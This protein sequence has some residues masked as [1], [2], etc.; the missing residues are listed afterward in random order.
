MSETEDRLRQ[1]LKRVTVDLGQ[2]R[3]RLREMEER[4][5]E[6]VAIVAMACRF[7]GGVTSPEELWELV[8]SGRDAIGGF[9][10]N[11]GWDLERLYH[12]DP[13]HPGT[14]Y[15]REGGFLHD[16]DLFDAALFGISPREALAMDPQQRVLLEVSWE[17]LERAGIAPASLKV[18]PTGV[19]VGA[20]VPGFGTPHIDHGSEGYL[21]TGNALSV[22]SGRVSYTLGLEGPALTVD[23]AC[24][25]S[26]VALHLACH[27]L[28]QGE[29]TLA[30]AGGVTVMA[31]P[32]MFTEFS[33]Q[34]ALSPD[35]RC[36][37]FAMAADGTGFSEGVGLVLLERLSDARRNG[38]R[39][40]AVVR[41]SAVNQDGTSN[42]L[43]A[44]NGPS[45]Q[46]VI[47]RALA[48]AGLSAAEVDVV[49][50]HG[51]GTRL[52]DPLEAQALL[53]TYGQ[54][55]PAERP[56]LL[57]SVKSNIGHTQGAAGV[58]GV[59]KMVMAMRHGALPASL[60][61][62]R[63]TEHVD[64]SS[65]A[66]SPVTEAVEWARADHPR[67]AGV[68]A[69]GMSGT[70]AHLILEE[71]PEPAVRTG[72][73][74]PLAERPGSFI[75]PWVVSARSEVALRAQAA[76]LVE[77]VTGGHEWSPADVGWSLST[78]RSVFEH[79]AVILG[80]DRDELVAGMTALARGEAH[81][82]LVTDVADGAA[83]GPVLVFPGQGGQWAGMGAELLESSP[84][85]AARIAE[86]ERALSPY[87]D[88]SLTEVLRD[89]AGAGLDRVDVVQPALWAVMVAL[90][91]L[92]AHHGVRPAAVVGHSQ[93][94]IAAACV[95]GA[96]SL[97]EGA[98]IVAVR[99]KALRRLS[100]H[101]TMASLGVGAEDAARLLDQAKD[102]TVAAVNGPSSTVISGFPDQV[103]AVVAAA[104]EQGLR[105]R[106]IDVDYASHGPQVDQITDELT[107][108]LAGIQPTPST[109]AFYSTVTGTRT[110][111]TTLD[112]DYWITNLR[113]PV[114][115]A[116][117]VEA[118]LDD[119]YRTFI[120][121][122]PHP[123]LTV[124]LQECLERA[125]IDGV[126][127]PTLRRDH[128]DA[129]QLMR[130]TAQAFAAGVEVDRSTWFPASAECGIVD[131]PTYAFQRERFWLAGGTDGMDATGLGLTPAGHPLLGAAVEL[132]DGDGYVL[133]GRLSRQSVAWLTDHELLGTVLLPGAL[134]VEWALRAADGVGCAGV[135]ELTLQAPLLLPETGALRI[136]VTVGAVGDGGRREVRVHSRPDDD[137]EAEWACHA[138]GTLT[139]EPVPE[140]EPLGGAWPPAGAEPADI[141][142]FYQRVAALGYT[143]GPAFRGLRAA[144]RHG[145]DLLAEVVLPEAAG[146][147]DGFGIHP[148]LLDAALHPV[149]LT[150]MLDDGAAWVP[151][152]WEGVSLHAVGA[153]T[154]RVR[155]SPL[156][157]ELDQ[158]FRLLVTDPAGDPV[159]SVDAVRMR[160]ADPDLRNAAARR[161][162]GL[163]ALDWIP[164]PGALAPSASAGADCAIIASGPTAPADGASEAVCHPTLQALAA[165]VDAGSA[166][167]RL[168]LAEVPVPGGTDPAGAGLAVARETLRLAQDWLAE[169]GLG[170]GHF[171]VVTRD[172]VTAT[173]D[174]RVCDPPAAA[175]WGLVRSAQSE[176]PDRFIL[177][178][179]DADTDVTRLIGAAS[180]AVKAGESQVAI[181]EGRLLVPRLRRAAA[182]DDGDRSLDPDG[183]VLITGGTG[184]LG[185]LV[186]EHLVR[187]GETGRLLLLSRRG[188]DAPGAQDLADRLA[189]LG[190]EVRIAAVDV[191]DAEALADT[192]RRIDPAHPLTG[193]IH[194]AGVLDDAMVTAQTPESLAR[195]WATKATAAA[196]L[197]RATADV[198]LAMFVLFSSAAAVMGSPGQSNYAAANAFCDALAAHRRERGLAGLSVAWG[199]W[200]D[201][202]GMTG[203]LSESGLVAR[204]SRAGIT[205]MPAGQ[206]LALLDAARRSGTGFLV[207]AGMDVRRLADGPVPVVLRGLVAP[208]RRRAAADG[209]GP[210]LAGRLAALEADRRSEA[211]LDVVREQ[212]AVVLGH[213]SAGDV[214]VEASF[215]NLGF[216][217]LTAVELRNRLATVTGLR[218]PATLAFDHPTPRTLAEHLCAR[219]TGEGVAPV[220]R[221]TSVA[222][223][224]EPIAIV[225]MACRYPGGVGSPE[226]LWDLVTSGRDA[227]GSFPEDR[228][229]N[230]E[231]LFAPGPDRPGTSHTRQ[232]GFLYDAGEFDA[233]F[234]G[235]S[236]REALASD[237]QQRLL[238]ETAW[239]ALERAGID[240]ASLKG[241]STG[242]YAGAM[243][244][245]Y[246]DGL[247]GAD[248]AMEGYEWLTG[249]GS[250][251]SGRT[252]FTFGFEGPAVTVDTACSSSLVA[253][254]L[255]CNAL[256][257]GEC[258]LALAGGVT[259]MATPSPFVGFSRQR[260]LAPD[261]RCKSFAASAD[262]TAISEGA[263]LVLLERLSDARRNGRRVLGVVRGS[264]VNQDGASNGLT[265]PNGPSQE[266]VI[267]A[268]LASA[269]L[270]P[271]DVDVVE[272]HGTG[273]TLG[274]PIEANALLAAYGR[275]RDR[276]LLVG[277][278]KSNIGH[279]QAAAGVAGVIK[280][281]LAMRRGVVPASLH[282]DEPSPHVDW[283]SGAVELVTEA[284]EWPGTGRPR[285]AGVSSFG[286]SG[287]NA[288]V[289]LEEAPE[290]VEQPEPAPMAGVL[291]WVIS[292]RG[293][294]ALRGQAAALAARIGD[295]PQADPAD[296]AWSLVTTRSTFDDRAVIVGDDRD[297]L[298]SGL[299]ALATGRPHP[300]L[301]EPA[302]RVT[303]KTV[304]LFS[305]QG[306]Q[307]VGMG[308]GLYGRFAV[309]ADAFDEVCGRLDPVLGCS[310][311]DVVF[312]GRGGVL[313][314]TTCAQ[315]GLFAVQVGLARLLGSFG[316]VPDVVIGH[317]IGEVAA[318]Y[319]AGVFD[320]GDACRLVGARAVLMGGLPVGGG[321]VAVEA[322]EEEV[323]ADVAALG[324]RVSVAA[325]NGPVATVVSGPVEL[326]ARVGAVW[327]G[328]GRKTK[329]LSVSHGFHSALM[330]PMLGE[331]GAAI[332]GVVF[333]VPVV[334]LVSNVSGLR[335]GEEVASPG[336][337]VRQVRE[338]VRFGPAVG[339]VAGEAGV[340]VELGPDPV[341][342]TAAQQ[343]LDHLADSDPEPAGDRPGPFLLS[344]L[345]RKQPEV[346]GL[347]HA[348]ARLHAA[349][350]SV[351][352]STWF[353][354]EPAR[355][356]V[357][358]PTY[359]FQRERYWLRGDRT[360]AEV[361]TA[362][363]RRLEH[364]LLRAATPLADGGLLLT[365]RLSATGDTDWLADHQVLGTVLVPGAVLAEW[366]L[367]AA[368]ESGCAGVEELVLQTPLVLPPSGDVA[369]Q[370]V[371]GSP[372]ADARRE[373]RVYSR[374]GDS[375]A[376]ADAPWTCHAT[377]LLTAEM[378]APPEPLD[379][380]WP[381]A[382]AE[383]LSTD[384]FYREVAAAGYEYGAA[385]QGVRAVWRNGA[386]LFATVELPDSVH[387][388][389]R[390]GIHPVLLDATLHAGLLDERL[391]EGEV[392]LPFLWNGVRL[393]AEKATCVR[394]R[395]TLPDTEKG[396]DGVRVT[397]ADTTGAP[398]L[399][400]GSLVTRPVPAGRPAFPGGNRTDGLFAVDWA[401]LPATSTE[402][403][404]DD[405]AVLG[406]DEP[407]LDGIGR[408]PGRPDQ[409]APAEAGPRAHYQDLEALTA[410]VR[411]GA[412]IAPIILTFVRPTGAG[413]ADGLAAS[414][415]AL[416]LLQ[417]WLAEPALAGAR[418]V[419]VT[420]GA[421]MTDAADAGPD[422]ASAAVW[423]LTRTAQAE[424]PG[425]FLLVDM[426]EGASGTGLAEAA[427]RAVR[428][429]ESEVAI[430]SDQV[431]V[432]RLVPADRRRDLVVP[433]GVRAWRLAVAEPGT[434]DNLVPVPCPEVLEPPVA[435]QVRVDVR[436]AGIN[437][438]DVLVGL[439]MVPGHTEVGGEGAGVVTAVGPG[440]MDL[441]VGDRVMGLF[442]GAFG[443]VT[444]ADARM[445]GP[446]PAG[447]GWREAAAAPVAFLT[448]WYGLVELAGLRPGESVLIH[449]A[450]GGVGM[451]A[452]QI[453]RHLGAE[454]YTTAS[455]GKHPVLEE[456]GVDAAHRASSR[457]LGFEAA[458]RE[459]TGGRG[460]DVVLNSLAGEFTDASLR[461]LAPGGRF[462][463]M[464]KTDIRESAE[465]TAEHPDVRYEVFDL[466]GDAGP[467]LIRRMLATLATLFDAGTLRPAPVRAWPLMRAR[468]ALRYLGQA[469]HV[470]KLVL[471]VPASLDPDGTVLITGGTGTLGGLVA[472]RFV[473]T[474]GVKRLVLV[475]RRGL[476]APGAHDLVTR[477]TELGGDVRVVAA[478]VGD[479]AAVADLIKGIDPRHPLT[480]VVH[481]AGVVADAVVTSQSR[482]HLARVWSAKAAAAHHLH[483]A[484]ADLEPALFVTFSST[485][486][487]LGSP[488]Q[489]NYAAAN[490]FCDA[491]A[492]HHQVTG[493][494]GLSI[495]W[496]LW[497]ETSGM[498]AGLSAA[499]L[500]RMARAGVGALTTD[501]ALSLL[502][503]ADRY[504]DPHLLAVNLDLRALTAQ[505]A[506]TLPPA[507]RA[508]AGGEGRIRPTAVAADPRSGDRPTR[509]AGLSETEQQ[510][511]LLDLVRSHVAAV[512]GHS[513]PESV[514]ADASFK[515]LGFDSLTAVELR[516]RLSSATGL[517]LPPALIFDYPQARVLADHLRRRMR[518]EDDAT[519]G[520]T[521]VEPVLGE[522]ARL[523]STLQDLVL[524]DGDSTAVTAR[525]ESLVAKWKA[526]LTPSNGGSAAERLEVA[527]TDQVLDFIDNELGLS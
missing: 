390:F 215:R 290:P 426:D 9:P 466:V 360:A 512:L 516:N 45:Q 491:L 492:A 70:N 109:V 348:L 336:Y 499:D 452:V 255:A 495:G 80:E 133:T 233:G 30:L 49:E 207:A 28:R 391:E 114:R 281:V 299:D 433:D 478:D 34:R 65:G 206:G 73:A 97:E 84:V 62:D 238:L 119:G 515:D 377:G 451:A 245:D 350:R 144:W 92:W 136:Q 198:P 186:A 275:G 344:A 159:L 502:D 185:G 193:V 367:R 68:S 110:D 261:G 172:A 122:G 176:N 55:R 135:D 154:V 329:V 231:T 123:L 363:S 455:P 191:T 125:G 143:Y 276:A 480:G 421:V 393:W 271:G 151:F 260:G 197:H 196:N 474:R 111:T 288:H 141:G 52:G 148:V 396:R 524:N 78:A 440:V 140:A 250:V 319:V 23:T 469:R 56:L 419:L 446:V 83:V 306:S 460:V 236:P 20:G 511:V 161:T 361:D 121:V 171:V 434:V 98:R 15:V 409:V 268:A 163:F 289:I 3:Q 60:H 235:I 88:W 10:T 48:A 243:Y 307:R 264:A 253:M 450:T 183:T 113:R 380:R 437:F 82:G 76:T 518:P 244:H 177:L 449:T 384:D 24:S 4:H 310:L 493:R 473:R 180:E 213:G 16:A 430:R 418:L 108:D 425:R 362:V 79:R 216:D 463:E 219:L 326:V 304:F 36:K 287:T 210:A 376:S 427:A 399:S 58:A 354:D 150:G 494:P 249:S 414:E 282:V 192:I 222:R 398:V 356:R 417:G 371:V 75:V 454:V 69:F 246:A 59:I 218:L 165:A 521:D 41:G 505:P 315:A 314:H 184:T 200:A 456:M 208:G 332:E 33:R 461:L 335:A 39:V 158:G 162:R 37:P 57:G 174:D 352:W 522:L 366:A 405:W 295:D 291:P 86:C 93:G 328:R 160:P 157:K 95:A 324:G 445:V 118:L 438:R 101:G 457:D 333:R 164:L 104:Q 294:E 173:S 464:G 300:G 477:L 382:G 263:G 508:L 134:L 403:E 90:A 402:T 358:L 527:S 227:I 35:G 228:G 2:T 22:L 239:E 25:S 389:E 303:G 149:F 202:S 220:T 26:L 132:A 436:A 248:A 520:V 479:P 107:A 286:A 194:A 509:L 340:F 489:A 416:E 370:V 66:V 13:D 156:G 17:L 487:A 77:W 305:G 345:S 519:P 31:T 201:A 523:E 167:P 297:R 378:S 442:A 47:R 256:R 386:D 19:Y 212:V 293:P 321:M 323:A 374:P 351:D 394:V 120:E 67:R 468:Q 284:V 375:G 14:S 241:S 262:G 42:G 353:S 526:T 301:V 428:A 74:G 40:L 170:D 265:A 302:E 408:R 504:G 459:A 472:E 309:F 435:G 379:G 432:P 424:H 443:P 322:S 112:T 51:T 395:L 129:A 87:V 7:P 497:A 507:L 94:E 209:A 145:R 420:R 485:A 166:P 439:G 105:A 285:R 18:T 6:P 168:T 381:P 467:D 337:W 147:H 130:A 341:L 500:E 453:A 116:D 325:V 490:A 330:D 331:F 131:L 292:A 385:F 404:Q 27:A 8:T 411:T 229:W 510:G 203:H 318:A 11:R 441:A 400:I 230:L 279:T 298:L 247:T 169:P 240:P 178:D 506:D 115:F 234:F 311:R 368:D 117:T 89:G 364:G 71:G 372:G 139:S 179:A 126:T 5:Q 64:W 96:L 465:V 103:A 190:A 181:R 54:G 252:A 254:H 397:V 266:R 72:P 257:A 106:L 410:A 127:V 501:Q 431:L 484:T 343:V 313:D 225:S 38:H 214:G 100:G 349:G 517:R 43:T 102:V 63:L 283:S 447:W 357:E 205:P 223:T 44:P 482:E 498:T 339:R 32:N 476:D 269:G 387:D 422:P 146:T 217:S 369:V 153:G 277:S 488:G 137:P 237:P 53:A 232:G 296:V 270:G 475:G 221:V 189:E 346:Q 128:G 486:A 514:Q 259:V 471:D 211:V 12:P 99:S 195:V 175:A 355:R 280:M 274:D 388:P 462:I 91:A 85:F 316:V 342:T 226:D 267:G 29:C 46:R 383:R 273:T 327:A 415:T 258:D 429:D 470:G 373:I 458:I 242:V 413:P 199:L 204:M 334:P 50:A 503:A 347:C 483:A 21:V 444:V 312:E 182:E 278:V 187:S 525:L 251:I 423:G 481:A 359:A 142:D 412:P 138:I 407:A 152:T 317:S 513:D 81:P 124:N 496:G 365:G 392:L 224:D 1:Y 272:A 406:D 308:A 61:V 188:M 320:L 448:A 155:L 338:A 401:P